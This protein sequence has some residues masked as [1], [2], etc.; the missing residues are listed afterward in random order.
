M[1][2]DISQSALD[3]QEGGDHYRLL[4]IQPIEFIHANKLGFIEANVVKYVSRWRQKNGI[5]DLKKAQHYLALLIELETRS[6]PM[7]TSA[8]APNNGRPE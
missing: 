7:P 6:S 1:D 5:A 8:P 3:T 4:P 2:T